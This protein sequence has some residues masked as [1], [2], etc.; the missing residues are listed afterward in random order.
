MAIYP[1]LDEIA[2]RHFLALDLAST[3]DRKLL[4]I[5]FEGRTSRPD[6]GRKNVLN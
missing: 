4:V 5:Y 3:G 6:S 2:S 1:V